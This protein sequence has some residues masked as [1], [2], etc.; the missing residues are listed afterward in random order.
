MEAK[1]CTHGTSTKFATVLGNMMI[2]A[3]PRREQEAIA[4]LLDEQLKSTAALISRIS[5]AIDRLKEFRTAMISAAVT[6]K[7]DVRETDGAGVQAALGLA[8]VDESVFAL[9]EQDPGFARL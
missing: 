6:G 3:P 7:I 5:D 9:Q 1:V 2:V 4:D 8:I